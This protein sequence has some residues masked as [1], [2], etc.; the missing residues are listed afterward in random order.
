MMIINHDCDYYES[1]LWRI[2]IRNTMIINH[3]CNYCELLSWWLWIMIVMIMNYNFSC[4][5]AS[6]ATSATNT[7][8]AAGLQIYVPSVYPH[9]D[10]TWRSLI[11]FTSKGCDLIFYIVWHDH[12]NIC[13]QYYVIWPSISKQMVHPDDYFTS[14]WLYNL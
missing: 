11:F 7:S 9:F 5:Q 13:C 2:W 3:D 10:S 6:R 4:S 14:I 12:F 8:T 1:W